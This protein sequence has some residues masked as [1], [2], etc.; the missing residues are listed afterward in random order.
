ME[1]DETRPG[2]RRHTRRR[3]KEAIFVCLKTARF[4]GV[5]CTGYEIGF[6]HNICSKRLSLCVFRQGERQIHGQ[7]HRR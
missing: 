7:T 5:R 4:L 6:L 2:C 1:S 3:S